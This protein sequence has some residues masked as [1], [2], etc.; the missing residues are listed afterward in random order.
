MPGKRKATDANKAL[1]LKVQIV[2][3]QPEIWRRVIVPETLTLRE[4]HAVIQGAMGWQ[5][6]HLH[7][8]EID[9]KRFEL[10]EDD[11]RGPEE[12]YADERNQ[13]LLT[14]L[15]KGMQF[16]YVYDFGDDW[17]HLVT[18]EG[19]AVPSS[20]GRHLLR[21]VAGERAC[22]PE[23]CGGVYRYPAFLEALAD[24]EHREHRDTVEWAGGFEPEPFN[25]TQANGL[26]QA[27]CAL[28]RERGWGFAQS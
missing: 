16:F 6:C 23:D 3:I 12:G 11:K 9:G 17:K 19:I 8:F 4:L 21:C 24:P 14:I 26:I 2:G 1:Q 25:I 5:D 28:Y 15:S 27:V 7:I 22:P 20:S 18:V 13:T 10:P